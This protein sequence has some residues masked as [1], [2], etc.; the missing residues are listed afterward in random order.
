MVIN[1]EKWENLIQ[2]EEN[3]GKLHYSVTLHRYYVTH[4]FPYFFLLFLIFKNNIYGFWQMTKNYKN[5][6]KLRENYE[7]PH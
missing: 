6:E 5:L 2:M 3:Y 7:M 4:I 1:S